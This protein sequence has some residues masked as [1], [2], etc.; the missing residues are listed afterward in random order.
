MAGIERHSKTE[1]EYRARTC[2]E[3]RYERTPS[4]RQEEW[5][6]YCHENFGDRSEGSS[7]TGS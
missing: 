5:I 2:Y 3:L 7:T 4:I 6:K 1:V